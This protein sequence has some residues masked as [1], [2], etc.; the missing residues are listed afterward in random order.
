MRL[1]QT[2]QNS[3]RNPAVPQYTYCSTICRTGN[4]S[5]ALS[6]TRHVFNETADNVY[7]MRVL[8]G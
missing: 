3:A 2:V 4:G 7:E 6:W 1:C 8:G 5:L